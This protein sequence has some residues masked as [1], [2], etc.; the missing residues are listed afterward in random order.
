[1]RA[2]L[3][4]WVAQA[5]ASPA[6]RSARWG[7]AAALRRILAN[8]VRKSFENFHE[9]D[10]PYSHLTAQLLPALTER[11]DVDFVPHLVPAP[12]PAAAPEAARLA[13]YARKDAGAAG[14]DARIDFQRHARSR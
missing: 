9:I 12:E 8:A 14:L 11:Y 5:I 2:K 10:D 6:L 1:M 7:R 3:K 13:A 4:Q